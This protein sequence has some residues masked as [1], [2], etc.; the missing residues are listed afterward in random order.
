MDRS[1]ILTL[2]GDFTWDFGQYFFIETTEGNFIW[3][4]PEYGGDN[5][6]TRYEGSYSDWAG[7]GFGRDKGR[8]II[9]E[10]I[11]EREIS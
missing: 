4:D 1:E 2:E 7:D 11:G 8:H 10:Y 9:G 5:L 6:I 3:S